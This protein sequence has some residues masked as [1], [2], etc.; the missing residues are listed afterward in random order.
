MV[1]PL[2]GVHDKLKDSYFKWKLL[3]LDNFFCSGKPLSQLRKGVFVIITVMVW[4]FLAQG[5]VLL[6]SVA[7]LQ[8]VYHCGNGLWEAFLLAAWKSVFLVVLGTG[9]GTFSSFFSSTISAGH[10]LDSCLGDSGVK[11]WTC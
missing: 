10:C 11:L 4:I 7:L 3:I 2:H 6:G 9:W 5:M 8:E 1:K